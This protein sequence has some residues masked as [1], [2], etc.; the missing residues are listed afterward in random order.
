VIVEPSGGWL[1]VSPSHRTGWTWLR[2]GY[3]DHH[4]DFDVAPGG[5]RVVVTWSPMV[6][7]PYVSTLLLG[8]VMTYLLHLHRRPALH[9]G[10]VAWHGAAFAFAG[11]QGAGKST[12]GSALNERGCTPVSDDVAGLT[13]LQRDWAVFPGLTGIRL[14]PEAQAAL[15]VPSTA[16]TPLWP[17][18]PGL[19]GVDFGRLEDKGVVCFG[20]AA[21]A[22]AEPLPLAGIFVLPARSDAVAGPRTTGVSAAAAVPDLARHMLV[23]A[24]L[25]SAPDRRTFTTLVDVARSTPVRTVDRPDSL[26]ALPQVCDVVRDEME[27]L[28]P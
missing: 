23:P 16:V 22:G 12:L 24:W 4:V 3:T 18:S 19:N 15:G 10:V 20:V 6:P 7:P 17:P 14:T 1:A 11:V 5:S 28:R 8:T 9:A 26:E 27:R 2:F 21:G 25:P 13:R